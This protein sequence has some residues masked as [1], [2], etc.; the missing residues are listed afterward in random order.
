MCD[1]TEAYVHGH[2]AH[3]AIVINLLH[4]GWLGAEMWLCPRPESPLVVV[5]AGVRSSQ[6][7][8]DYTS[9]GDRV[10]ADVVGHA[11]P[12]GILAT[13]D[14]KRCSTVFID[15]TSL[16]SD[17]WFDGTSEQRTSR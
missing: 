7:W 5:T 2:K 10:D 1:G 6:A 16:S 9:D 4:V 12:D 17:E 13:Q 15:E 3:Y 8:F 11:P 14:L